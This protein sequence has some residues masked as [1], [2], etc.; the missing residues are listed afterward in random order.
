DRNLALG[1]RHRQRPY[2]QS[3]VHPLPDPRHIDRQTLIG[4]ADDRIER[5]RIEPLDLCVLHREGTLALE[6]SDQRDRA[7]AGAFKA[8]VGGQPAGQRWRTAADEF[9]EIGPSEAQLAAG[10]D[11]V[12]AALKRHVTGD[13]AAGNRAV[14][15]IKG[16]FGW[17]E[18]RD[19][20]R[21]L[22]GEARRESDGR[23]SQLDPATDFTEEALLERRG[24]PAR[25]GAALPGARCGPDHR[26]PTALRP[27]EGARA[28]EPRGQ[29]HPWPAPQNA[30]A[31]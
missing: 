31:P 5:S 15:L 10:G 4:A 7:A 22:G 13:A 14:D 16:E 24:A 19:G 17:I 28:R 25:G 23:R 12:A 11:T 26:G 21:V 30:C 1:Q 2:R 18:M 27:H 20:A 3:L 6:R 9:G 8:D 29:S